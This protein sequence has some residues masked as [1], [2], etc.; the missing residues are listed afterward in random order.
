MWVRHAALRES[1]LARRR[2]KAERSATDSG[3]RSVAQRERMR[4]VAE[5]ADDSTSPVQR[6]K[7]SESNTLGFGD[8]KWPLNDGQIPNPNTCV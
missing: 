3:R 4:L 7:S 1:V 8:K 2:A 5:A 6:C